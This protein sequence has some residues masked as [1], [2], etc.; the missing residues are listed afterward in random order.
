MLLEQMEIGRGI[1]GIVA[2]YVEN[3][4]GWQEAGQAMSPS[5][6]YRGADV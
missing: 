5:L 3:R 6:S 2:R 4:G 1:D